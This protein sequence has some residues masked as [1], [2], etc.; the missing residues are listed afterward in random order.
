MHSDSALPSFCREGSYGPLYRTYVPSLAG[1]VTA[2][3]LAQ[4]NRME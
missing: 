4:K 3:G 1:D 2:R